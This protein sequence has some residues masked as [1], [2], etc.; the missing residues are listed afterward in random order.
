MTGEYKL[1]PSGLEAEAKDLFRAGDFRKAA[2]LFSQA[3]D[4]YAGLPQPVLAAEMRNNQCVALL[5]ARQPEQ[6]LSAVQGSSEVFSRTGD[7]LKM[8]MALANEASALQD[9]GRS[10]DAASL[11][12]A[13]AAVFRELGE[14][15]LLLQ[16]TQSLSSLKLKSRDFLGALLT[17]QQGLENLPRPT[18]R[19]KL[20]S[21]LLKIPNR[22][23]SG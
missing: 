1:D 9:L 14:G 17:M 3:A 15:D 13:A 11:F 12:D 4:L 16:T 20:L 5:K 18:F 22:L 7:R 2:E 8:G 21:R 10:A 23:L 6:A 19:Q